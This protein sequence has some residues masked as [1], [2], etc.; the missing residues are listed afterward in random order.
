MPADPR[1]EPAV[2][3][4]AEEPEV[5]LIRH[6]QTDWSR[7]NRHTGLTDLPLTSAGEEAA[8]GLA[9]RLAKVTFD[10]V[11]TSPLQRARRTAALA[12]FPDAEQTADLHEWDYGEYEGLT[13]VQIFD[14]D[15][16]WSIWSDGCPGGES[17]LDVTERVDRVIA[18]CRAVGGRTALF[19]H[20]HVLRTLAGRWIEESVAIGE[21]LP[22]DTAAISILSVDRGSPTLARWNAPA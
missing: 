8:S 17:P 16:D 1:S 15:P 6:G 20:G 9:P 5:W 21:H 14:A 4:G 2:N 12:G 18:R 7:A 19:A 10:L 11:L 3:P 22:L 13:R